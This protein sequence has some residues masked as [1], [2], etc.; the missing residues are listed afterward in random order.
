M[1]DSINTLITSP[2][3]LKIL[4]GSLLTLQVGLGAML[5]AAAF[6]LIGAVLSLSQ[7][8]LGRA[9][10]VVYAT[11]IRGVPDLILLFLIYYG[12]QFALNFALESVGYDEFVEIKP[13]LAGIL[14]LGFIYG[15]Y[16]SE[17]FRGA[18]Q[19]VPR[20]QSEAG[21]AFG[22]SKGRVF[23]R[24]VLPQMVRFALP[25]ITHVW[26]VLLKATALVSIIGL[27]DMTALA[28][29]AG[30][31]TRGEIA[32]SN[33]LF[34]GFVALIFLAITTLSLGLLRLLERKYSVGVRK[35]QL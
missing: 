12:G 24:M 33:I 6:G 10:A 27:I 3:T 13:L 14:S 31:A 11:L 19:A 1:F 20:G 5:L 15:A 34:F 22:M 30:A 18:I 32:N 17:V 2:W 21:W 25:G 35:G 28:K 7:Y 26:L 9:V 16:M 23:R 4:E 8:R 29:Q